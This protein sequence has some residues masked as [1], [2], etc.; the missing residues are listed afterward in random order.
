MS[1]ARILV[2][3]DDPAMLRSTERV[4]A[5][6][7]LVLAVRSP[8]EALERARAF[9]PDLAV[10]DIRMADMDGFELASRLRDVVRGLDVI[11]V[12]GIV[13]ELDAQLIRSIR[14]KAF[15]FIQKPFD[16]DVLITLVDRC[17]EVRRLAAENRALIRRL[18]AELDEARAFQAGLMP[19]GGERIQRVTVAARY[20]PCHDMGGDFY[21][22]ADAGRGGI[23]LVMADVSG[24]GVSAA[25]MVGIIKA[26][27]RAARVDQFEPLAVV[28][29]IANAIRPF[30]EARFVTLFCARIYRDD[31]VL[32]YVTAGHPRPMLR[33]ADGS[34][35]DL[36]RT[37]PL[38][39]PA[40][41]DLDW[42]KHRV[43]IHPGELLLV[44]TDGIT[45]AR[46]G[47]EQFGRGRTAQ[48]LAQG[49]R[50]GEPLLDELLAAVDGWRG[51]RPAADD[52]TLLAA[53][54]EQG[55]FEPG[56]EERVA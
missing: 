4:L 52:E 19:E 55:V 9:Q 22:W 42:Q 56:G 47:D 15:Y 7:H 30:D 37:G 25:M 33:R 45:E 17:L 8:A 46:N 53:T 28:R 41:P 6:R 14:E 21:D 3:D 54:L 39:T 35:E 5:S 27:Y 20:K 31:R 18:E 10:L 13:H 36:L 29:R 23:S 1:E 43:A 49:P 51:G 12:T 34:V 50:D 24:H 11:F 2:V 44:F 16:R 40:H 32:E 38:I 48:I 26:A